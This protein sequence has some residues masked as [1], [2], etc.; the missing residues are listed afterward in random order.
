VVLVAERAGAVVGYAY[1]RLEER[2]W[3]ALLEACGALHDL[4]VD[5]GAR[6]TGAGRLLAEAIIDKLTAMGA[7]RIVLHTGSKNEPAQR[8]FAKLGWRMTMVEMTRES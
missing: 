8:L 3:N 1:A 4:W 2:D 5:E 7:P 6:G